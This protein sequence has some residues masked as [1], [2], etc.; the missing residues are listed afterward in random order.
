MTVIAA[1]LTSFYS[2]RLDVHDLP[3]QA[4]RTSSAYDHAH[5]SPWVILIPL[6]F[7]AAGSILAGLPF[8]EMFAGH[9]VAGVLPRVAQFG[10]NNHILRG[11]ASRALDGRLRADRDDGA[12]LRDL[13]VLL[14]PP[15]GH[16]GARSRE[17]HEPLYEFLLNKW[18]FDELYDL[19]FV[20]PAFWIGRR[21]LEG[22]RRP[23]HR[24]ARA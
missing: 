15:P 6:I 12:R 22:R 19:I 10:P 24:R 20:R 1:L 7:L 2:W 5:E 9:H 23:H 8:K 16:S 14:H 3:R 18:Y 17:Q 13:L 21:A 11:H 4:A